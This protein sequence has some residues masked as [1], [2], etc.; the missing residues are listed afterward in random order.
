MWKSRPEMIKLEVDRALVR[1][2]KGLESIGP[3]TQVVSQAQPQ[4]PNSFLSS[5]SP[6]SFFNNRKPKAKRDSKKDSASGPAS[7]PGIVLGLLSGFHE[8]AF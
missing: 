3:V 4:H 8:N 7:D 5:L 2:L 6:V 1:I